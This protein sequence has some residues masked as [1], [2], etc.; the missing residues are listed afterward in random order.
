[1]GE[2][3]RWGLELHTRETLFARAGGLIRLRRRPRSYSGQ[4]LSKVFDILQSTPIYK[5]AMNTITHRCA[6]TL[7]AGA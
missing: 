1:M 3:R 5:S 2:P 6:G 7:I 4:K